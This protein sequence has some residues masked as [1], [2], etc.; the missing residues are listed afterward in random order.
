MKHTEKIAPV[1]AA[2]SALATLACCVPIAIA[3]G[4]AT[5]S[6]AIVAG[7]YR[8]WFLGASAVLLTRGA[9][10]VARVRRTCSTR[11]SASMVILAVSAAIVLLVVLLPQVLAGLIA[12]WLP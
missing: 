7:S 1:A 2:F 8:W 4:T 10:Q 3:A 9:V 6:L 5:A 12:D 11:G